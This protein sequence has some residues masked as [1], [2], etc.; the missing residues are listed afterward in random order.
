MKTPDTHRI[1]FRHGMTEVPAEVIPALFALYIAAER[2]AHYAERD[3]SD[4]ECSFKTAFDGVGRG[5]MIMA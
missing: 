3:A 5:R 2:A 1:V 4:R